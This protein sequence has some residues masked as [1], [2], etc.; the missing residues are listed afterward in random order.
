[1][2]VKIFIYNKLQKKIKKSDKN[3]TTLK[4]LFYFCNNIILN[5]IGLSLRPLNYFSGFFVYIKFLL[6]LHQ[7]TCTQHLFLF[8]SFF[9]F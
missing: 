1:M 6:Y 5:F 4:K 9:E 8:L 3:I 7:N 2:Y